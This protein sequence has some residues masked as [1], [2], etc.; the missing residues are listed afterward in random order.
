MGLCFRSK[1]ARE[2]QVLVLKTSLSDVLPG[3]ETCVLVRDL[4]P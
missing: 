4:D 3:C 1:L 2:E